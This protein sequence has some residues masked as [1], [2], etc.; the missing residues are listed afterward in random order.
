IPDFKPGS[1]LAWVGV[2]GQGKE[3][4]RKRTDINRV[5]LKRI[6]AVGTFGVEDN[7]AAQVGI[8]TPEPRI[9]RKEKP[10]DLFIDMVCDRIKGDHA[11]LYDIGTDPASYLDAAPFPRSHNQLGPKALDRLQAVIFRQC[12]SLCFIRLDKDG[13]AL[14]RQPCD[15]D[16]ERYRALFLRALHHGRRSPSAFGKSSRPVQMVSTACAAKAACAVKA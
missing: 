2:N 14:L 13:Q 3:L 9:A 12:L 5:A 7:F 16:H 4:L 11:S 10:L 8:L 15:M 6:W 1:G